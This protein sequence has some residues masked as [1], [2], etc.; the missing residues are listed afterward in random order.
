MYFRLNDLRQDGG[1]L[2]LLQTGPHLAPCAVADVGPG[3]R[4]RGSICFQVKALV[5]ASMIANC[6]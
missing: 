4:A 1:S 2:L 3:S 5:A 6:F